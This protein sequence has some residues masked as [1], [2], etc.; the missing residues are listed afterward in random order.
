M[1]WGYVAFRNEV[2]IARSCR[3]FLVSVSCVLDAAYRLRSYDSSAMVQQHRTQR[4]PHVS[5]SALARDLIN[6]RT[7]KRVAFHSVPTLLN[8]D[9]EFRL[10]A[11]T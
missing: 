1:G 8:R 5:P 6:G 9:V 4:A 11:L 7:P 2:G 10:G 3:E